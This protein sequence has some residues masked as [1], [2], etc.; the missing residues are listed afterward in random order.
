MYSGCLG[1]IDWYAT[2]K[3]EATDKNIFVFHQPNRN[4]T[5]DILPLKKK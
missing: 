1:N 2:E 3:V 5:Y 4:E